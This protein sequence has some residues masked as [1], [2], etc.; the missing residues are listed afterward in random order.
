M[1]R[2]MKSTITRALYATL[3]IR[4]QF[5]SALVDIG[6]SLSSVSWNLLQ[7][8]GFSGALEVYKGILRT[9]NR[10]SMPV[11]K[12]ELRVQLEEFQPEFRAALLISI[13]D[14]LHSLLRLDF[15][16]ANDCILC[17]KEKNSSVGRY[18]ERHH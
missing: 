8:L 10:T 13:V 9:A 11:K 7:S 17:A 5:V 2:E 4:G 14:A 3:L 6:S 15:P 1:T 12:A 16:I 18:S